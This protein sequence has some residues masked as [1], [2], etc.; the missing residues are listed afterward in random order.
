M[1][2][3]FIKSTLSSIIDGWLRLSFLVLGRGLRED[4]GD[5]GHSHWFWQQDG[6]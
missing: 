3:D 1:L 2:N 5:E 4:P 6:S